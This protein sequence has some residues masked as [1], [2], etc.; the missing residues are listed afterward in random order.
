MPGPPSRRWAWG[1][2][3]GIYPVLMLM[4][5]GMLLGVILHQ[6]SLENGNPSASPPCHE[7]VAPRDSELPAIILAA[8]YGMRLG[9][10]LFRWLVSFLVPNE[11]GARV[12]EWR[13]LFDRIPAA[14]AMVILLLVA[15]AAIESLLIL[16]VGT[17]GGMG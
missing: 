7:G 1:S 16:T 12:R 5:N 8:A 14:V 9:I 11:R 17:G 15:A 10:T 4:A 6:A 13:R 2:F 3:L